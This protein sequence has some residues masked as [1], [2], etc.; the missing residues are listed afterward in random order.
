MNYVRPV[1][2]AAAALSLVISACSQP[3][4]ALQPALQPQFGTVKDDS[5]NIGTVDSQRGHVFIG[6]LCGQPNVSQSEGNQLY[7]RRYDR[8]GKLVW[9]NFANQKT[10]NLYV[11]PA[12][13]ELDSAGNVLYAWNQTKVNSRGEQYN[14]T[15]SGFITKLNASGTKLWQKTLRYVKDMVFDSQGNLYV[16]GATTQNI[17]SVIKYSS[18][19]KLLWERTYPAS[20]E[21]AYSVNVLAVAPD[22]S[23]YAGGAE[24]GYLGSRVYKIHPADGRL[25]FNIS[26]RGD[27]VIDLE[28]RNNA[29]FALA[30]I[31][32]PDSYAPRLIKVRT[33]G[34][35]EWERT[36]PYD[37]IGGLADEGNAIS[38]DAQGNVYLTGRIRDDISYNNDYF[39]RK[40]TPSGA[41]ALNK[42]NS[43]P[44]TSE[45]GSDI[46]VLSGAE[47]Y[48]VGSTDGKVNG[49]NQGKRDAFLVR[50]D[51]QANRVWSR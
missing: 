42:V 38:T 46:S 37:E 18:A 25:L 47:L 39:V 30:H 43:L 14:E 31:D 36:S 48:L 4:D 16:A 41:L 1:L 7:F 49:S 19:G 12:D 29:V 40:Y 8:S 9:Q 21:D 28:F 17:S 50:L 20:G 44:G 34:T 23:L 32:A 5:A 13:V 15:R 3:Q 24:D 51:A 33:N 27:A 35:I 11:E 2:L 10:A 26:V 22:G 45:S 6:G